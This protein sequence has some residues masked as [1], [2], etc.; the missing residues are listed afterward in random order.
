MDSQL[1]EKTQIILNPTLSENKDTIITFFKCAGEK[2]TATIENERV[3]Y[4][5]HLEKALCDKCYKKEETIQNLLLRRHYPE[6]FLNF[7]G[8][9]KDRFKSFENFQGYDKFKKRII[10]II[11]DNSMFNLLFWGNVGNGKS[12]IAKAIL[13]KLIQKGC[14][15]FD[16]YFTL[17]A[18][19]LMRIRDTYNNRGVKELEIF[20]YY[21]EKK[22][23][24]LDELGSDKISDWSP[25]IFTYIIEKRLNQ[26]KSTIITT[27]LNLK[28][29]EE[30][31]DERLASRL[32]LYTQIKFEMPD[33]RKRRK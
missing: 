7:S 22:Y 9:G 33:Y 26:K 19:F 29:I 27:N 15:E 17:A 30:K 28:E 12:H 11:D 10:D 20:E 5:P 31:F 3:L 8:L 13:R 2:C 16:I 6:K 24:V 4:Y 32:S 1:K 25:G 23:L 18:D 21:C 14:G